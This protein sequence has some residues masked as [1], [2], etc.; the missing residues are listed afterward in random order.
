M[1]TIA[2]FLMVCRVRIAPDSRMA[3]L[4]TNLT[5]CGFGIYMVHYFFTCLGYD[6][7]AWLHIPS[8]LRIP[9]SALIMLASSW[10]IVAL[11]KKLFGKASVYLL[12]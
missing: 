2:C 7:G 9:F 11:L 8:P 1:M 6:L 5:T 12:G 10:V 3:R 4:L